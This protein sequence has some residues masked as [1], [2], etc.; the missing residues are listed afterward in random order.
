MTNGETAPTLQ[1]RS[2]PELSPVQRRTITMSWQ[3]RARPYP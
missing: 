2:E 3:S 1:E